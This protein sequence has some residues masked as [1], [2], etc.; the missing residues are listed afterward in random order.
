MPMIQE[1]M[2]AVKEEKKKKAAKK[3]AKAEAAAA[4]GKTPPS[5]PGSEN[6]TLSSPERETRFDPNNH[7]D[8]WVMFKAASEAEQ[9]LIIVSRKRTSLAGWTISSEY[10]KSNWK[11]TFPDDCVI[12]EYG[13]ITLNLAPGSPSVKADPNSENSTNL[14]WKDAV[15]AEPL[16][17]HVLNTRDDIV[18]RNQDGT[19]QTRWSLSKVTS[20][21]PYRLCLTIAAVLGAICGWELH[22][23]GSTHICSGEG[24]GH[25]GQTSGPNC[26]G[27]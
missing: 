18:I 1:T 14:M 7:G 22:A 15:S 5:S 6:T 10:G 27:Y 11:Y 9:D 16:Q 20:L 12:D 2:L 4:T 17:E 25:G 21:I 8:G 13:D 24:S 19:L 26:R 3:A 23:S